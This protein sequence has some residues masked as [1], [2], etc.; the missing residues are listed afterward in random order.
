MSVMHTNALIAPSSPAP[1]GQCV[2]VCLV[3]VKGGDGCCF[4]TK[5]SKTSSAVLEI[6]ILSWRWEEPPCRMF[7]HVL[8]VCVLSSS[9]SGG[10]SPPSTFCHGD[11]SYASFWL[12]SH[13]ILTMSLRSNNMPSFSHDV[14]TFVRYVAALIPF[15]FSLRFSLRHMEPNEPLSMYCNGNSWLNG[16]TIRHVQSVFF[17]NLIT[18]IWSL[19]DP[20]NTRSSFLYTFINAVHDAPPNLSPSPN[21]T[22]GDL[23]Y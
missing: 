18:L 3:W 17:F 23:I 19:A 16:V 7:C 2:S 14:M 21:W 1:Y 11:V 15:A 22:R 13:N 6:H 12:N 4:L 5:T 8:F 9:W 10:R 20:A